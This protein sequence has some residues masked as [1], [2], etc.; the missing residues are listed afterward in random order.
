M[1]Y[2]FYM[3]D[4]ISFFLLSF[5]LSKLSDLIAWPWLQKICVEKAVKQ[6]WELAIS[7][8]A[9]ITSS[10]W[11]PEY[12]ELFRSRP[13]IRRHLFNTIRPNRNFLTSDDIAISLA[14]EI[15]TLGTMPDPKVI[16]QISPIFT[17]QWISH[18]N[19]NHLCRKYLAEKCGIK[20]N[21]ITKN[22]LSIR[23]LT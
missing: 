20:T 6:S 23:L 13:G 2:M 3:F 4:K 22:Y 19:S 9:E 7:D 17:K 8:T 16:G 15:Y 18:L 11:L 5:L 1:T 21:E 12:S 10:V 14:F